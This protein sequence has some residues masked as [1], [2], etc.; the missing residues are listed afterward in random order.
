MVEVIEIE[1][2]NRYEEQ[3]QIFLWATEKQAREEGKDVVSDYGTGTIL[4]L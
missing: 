4:A 2:N 3:E 1:N